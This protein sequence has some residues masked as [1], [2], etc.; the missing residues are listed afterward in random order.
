M[1]DNSI[2]ESVTVTPYG[3]YLI[4]SGP[5]GRIRL[6]KSVSKKVLMAAAE[7]VAVKKDVGVKK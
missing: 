1:K 6:L 3:R 2:F 7:S 5:G 4:V